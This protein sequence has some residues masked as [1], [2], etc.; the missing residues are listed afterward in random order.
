M[1]PAIWISAPPWAKPISPASSRMWR[2][3]IRPS[4]AS[5]AGDERKSRLTDGRACSARSRPNTKEHHCVSECALVFHGSDRLALRHRR[6]LDRKAAE[7]PDA[8]ERT[9]TDL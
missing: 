7:A 1:S 2:T 6:E 8:W 4:G 9:V 5:V 3:A